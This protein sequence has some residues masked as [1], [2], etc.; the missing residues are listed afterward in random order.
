M[1][2]ATMLAHNYI[3]N[4]DFQGDDIWVATANGLSHGTRQTLQQSRST[5]HERPAPPGDKKK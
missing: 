2:S 1:E 5:Q 3:L 4:L